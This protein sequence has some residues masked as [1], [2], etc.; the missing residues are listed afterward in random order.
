M[1]LFYVGAN[2]YYCARCGRH[3]DSNAKCP[4]CDYKEKEPCKQK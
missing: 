1:F 2:D 3:V 4:I